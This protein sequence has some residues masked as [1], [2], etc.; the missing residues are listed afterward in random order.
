MSATTSIH[1]ENS[2]QF[3]ND[4]LQLKKNSSEIKIKG[5]AAPS[6]K[7][8][9]PAAPG[10]T[11]FAPEFQL[12]RAVQKDAKSGLTPG[13]QAAGQQ[14]FEFFPKAVINESASAPPTT[15]AEQRKAALNQFRNSLPEQVAKAL[16][17]FRVRQW[18]MLLMM[19]YDQGSID[20]AHS[21]PALAFLLAQ[22]L[23]GDIEKI[24][25]LQCS[26]MRQRDILT[27]LGYPGTRAA[28]KVVSKIRPSSIT[29]DNWR[30]IVSMLGIEL[31]KEKSP[32]GHVSNINLGLMEIAV[33]PVA[34]SAAGPKLL[35]GVAK[36]HREKYRGRVVHMIR[37]ALEMQEDLQT[38]RKVTFF[39]DLQ[40]LYDV[41]ERVTGQYKRRVK[42]LN[43]AE[44]AAISGTF[45]DPPFPGVEG[46]IEPLTCPRD[47]VDEGEIQNNCVASYARKMMTGKLYV[48]RVMGPDRCTLSIVKKKHGWEIGELEGKYNVAASKQT[49][50]MV[51][52]W[53]KENQESSF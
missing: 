9:S 36:D 11:S 40:R 41:H 25:S 5:W 7:R 13:E 33:D 23:D 49:E 18:M 37:S 20:L 2:Y 39:H 48:Y 27:M 24:K 52:D 44:L 6:A 46:K 47:L 8:R 17:P 14:V 35:E 31:A 53:L 42:Q 50:K 32:L 10:W 38:E 43:D 4:Y 22:H 26:R 16:E 3:V 28:V 45:D 15:L 30:S 51:K 1:T 21:N 12:V 19:Y 29:T 34:S